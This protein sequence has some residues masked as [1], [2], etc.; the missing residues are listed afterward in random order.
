MNQNDFTK[1]LKLIGIDEI[2]TSK[3]T[4]NNIQS[5]T[6]DANATTGSGAPLEVVT[7]FKTIQ[8]L[9]NLPGPWA[10]MEDNAMNHFVFGGYVAPGFEMVMSAF[11]RNFSVGLELNAQLSCFHEGKCVLNVFGRNDAHPQSTVNYDLDTLQ[12]VFSSTKAVTSLAMAI[13]ADKGFFA[14]DDK[15]SKYWPEFAQNGKGAITIA[16]VMRHDSGLSYLDEAITMEDIESI[17]NPNGTLAK[18]FERSSAENDKRIYHALTRGWICSLILQK[19]DPKKRTLQQFI[20]EFIA[21]PLEIDFYCGISHELQKKKHLAT[22]CQQNPKYIFA[23]LRLPL[24]IKSAMNNLTE[25]EKVMYQFLYPETGNGND[26][27]IMLKMTDAVEGWGSTPDMPQSPRGRALEIGSAS[28]H[29][30]AYG[31]AKIAAVVANGGEIGGVRLLSENGVKTAL[32]KWTTK[33]MHGI[34]VNMPMCQGGW[35]DFGRAFKGWVS[36]FYRLKPDKKDTP[37]LTHHSFH[38]LRFTGRMGWFT[39]ILLR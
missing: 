30:N 15:V 1:T 11:Q 39:N 7:D 4:I 31:L 27:P 19:A 21:K 22:L 13:A 36:T 17:S 3:D 35:G 38:M 6:F 34:N 10:L 14:Y 23:N 28:G 2:P 9:R 37:S 33:F 26:K 29:T 24:R 32:D 20:D 12:V 18:K 25:T 8:R 16:D 5:F